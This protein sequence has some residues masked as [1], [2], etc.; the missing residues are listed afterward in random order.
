MSNW[1]QN[2]ENLPSICDNYTLTMSFY[3]SI[4]IVKLLTQN[5]FSVHPLLVAL[6]S[7]RPAPGFC[8]HDNLLL[9]LLP[10]WP[11]LFRWWHADHCTDA[12]DA[13]VD[14]HAQAVASGFAHALHLGDA[15]SNLRRSTISSHLPLQSPPSSSPSPHSTPQQTP[16]STASSLPILVRFSFYF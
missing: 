16:S 5:Y 14:A 1:P 2:R 6:H 15:L 9:R 11:S 7:L 13:N 8:I 10:Y 3:M 12:N 4:Y